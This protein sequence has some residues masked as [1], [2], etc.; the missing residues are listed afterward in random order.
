MMP[1][2]HPF[3]CSLLLVLF[4]GPLYAQERPVLYTNSTSALIQEL[5]KSIR[6]PHT[7]KMR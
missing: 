5:A 7:D 3:F 1:K 6:D 4:S 2:S